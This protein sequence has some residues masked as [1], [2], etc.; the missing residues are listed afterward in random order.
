M[1]F[2]ASLAARCGYVTKFCI[3]RHSESVKDFWE[4]YLERKETIAW[5]KSFLPFLLL[6]YKSDVV[7]EPPAAILDHRVVLRMQAKCYESRKT[8]T[9]S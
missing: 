6:A 5:R 4:G 8:E 1:P 7:V 9:S 2:P 3:I